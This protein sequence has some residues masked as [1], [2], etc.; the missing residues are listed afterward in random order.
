VIGHITK[1][2]LNITTSPSTPTTHLP[3]QLTTS[4]ELDYTLQTD[5]FPS[6]EIWQLT[7]YIATKVMPFPENLDLWFEKSVMV[8]A[9][10]C[11]I[12]AR[13]GDMSFHKK[14]FEMTSQVYLDQYVEV[15][16]KYKRGQNEGLLGVRK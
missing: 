12:S 2:L 7:D 5:A 14:I 6:Q 10:F 1:K 9:L 16:E 8:L 13:T 3:K 4:Q 11:G 15:R